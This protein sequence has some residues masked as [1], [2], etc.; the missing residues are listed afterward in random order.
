[1]MRMQMRDIVALGSRIIG[2]MSH[3]GVSM[4]P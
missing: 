3:A 2:D 4:R 1:M